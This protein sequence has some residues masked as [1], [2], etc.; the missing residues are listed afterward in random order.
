MQQQILEINRENYDHY[1][2]DKYIYKSKPGLT[3][4]I[5]E[6]I[7]KQKNEPEW[8][9]QKRLKAFEIFQKMPMP[10]WGPSLKDLDLGNI[11]YF[12]KADAKKNATK[13]EDVPEEIKKTFE[14]LGIPEAERKALAGAGTQ[15]ES[16][17]VYH[18]LKKE[19]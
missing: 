2:P 19:W 10:N 17:V 14:K 8:M 7:S 16:E 18:N 12:Q 5:V 9:L 15:Y 13:W 6:E 4:E 3:K 1:N 11:T